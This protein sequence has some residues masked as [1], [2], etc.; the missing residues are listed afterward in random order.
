MLIQLSN[1]T[2]CTNC[3]NMKQNVHHQ[4]SI[5][6]EFPYC[7][8]CRQSSADSSHPIRETELGQ[9]FKVSLFLKKLL[10]VCIVTWQNRYKSLNDINLPKLIEVVPHDLFMVCQ[11][12]RISFFQGNCDPIL[13]IHIPLFLLNNYQNYC[14][15]KQKFRQSRLQNLSILNKLCIVLCTHYLG[16]LY[17]AHAL[18]NASAC[19]VIAVFP[20]ILA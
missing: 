12:G 2:F 20:T 19:W 1:L 16:L 17:S 14:T 4:C 18:A 8:Y 7:F 13:I 3:P 6:T 15:G 10:G 5:R 9:T 11:M